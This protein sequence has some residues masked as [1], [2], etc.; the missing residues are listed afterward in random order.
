MKTLQYN[1][2]KIFLLFFFLSALTNLSKAQE[3]KTDKSDKEVSV[4]TMI[5]AHR[6]VFKAQSV[7]PT[8]GRVV[9]LNSEYDLSV[10]KDTVRS[11][12]PYFGRAYSAP[13]D[14]KGG[15]IDFLSKDFEYTQKNRKKGGWDIT[16]KPKDVNDVRELFLT[17]FDNG[18]ASLRVSSNN[19]ESISFNGYLVGK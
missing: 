2:P 13:M 19:R 14:G 11:Y 4:K 6:Y 18:S 17:V 16:I 7:H 10:S 3:E 8:R 15:G 5:D 9:Q 1:V 12:L